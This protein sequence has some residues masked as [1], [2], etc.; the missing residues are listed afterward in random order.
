MAEIRPQY[1]F[2]RN[3]VGDGLGFPISKRLTLSS[4]EVTTDTAGVVF[5]NTTSFQLTQ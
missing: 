4:V 2:K 1:P 5:K 3:F